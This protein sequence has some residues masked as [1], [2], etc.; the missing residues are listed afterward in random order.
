MKSG[1]PLANSESTNLKN[2]NKNT[3]KIVVQNDTLLDSENVNKSMQKALTDSQAEAKVKL[4]PDNPMVSGHINMLHLESDT[5]MVEG[6]GTGQNK[7]IIQGPDL[8]SDTSSDSSDSDD[9]TD[10]VI[11]LSP[12]NS[13]F[14]KLTNGQQ[15]LVLVDSGSTHS[16]IS[17]SVVAQHAD[18]R[19]IRP[20]KLAEP[21]RLNIAN[22]SQ[23][24]ACTKLNFA[25]T[26]Q[27][28]ELD[29]EA[30]VIPD[31]MGTLDVIIG[32]Q[33]LKKYSA[34]LNFNSHK[35]KLRSRRLLNCLK[36]QAAMQ[37]APMST[38]EV[39]IYGKIPKA[40]KSRDIVLKATGIGKLYL[41]TRTMVKFKGN[42]CRILLLNT[43]DKVVRL[44]KGTKV[45]NIDLQYS[46]CM[47][48]QLESIHINETS[49]VMF[50][51]DES[52]EGPQDIDHLPPEYFTHPDMIKDGV[53]LPPS[54]NDM[55]Y[56]SGTDMEDEVTKVFAQEPTES[57]GSN[58]IDRQQVKE[59]NLYQYPFLTEDDPRISQL[60]HEILNEQIDLQTDCLLG[61]TQKQQFRKLLEKHR[62]SFSLYGE[63]GNSEHSV[64]LEVTD[65]SPKWIRP[66][67]ASPEEKTIIDREMD[68]LHKLGVIEPG[69]SSFTSPVMLIPKKD[70]TKRCVLDL[71]LLN[72]RLQRLQYSF[73][74]VDDCLEIIGIKQSSVLSVLDLR[75]AFFAIKLDPESY[76]Y[77]GLSTYAGGRSFYFCRL[78]MGLS[79]S[80]SVFSHY[81]NQVLSKIPGHNEFVTSYMDDL[82]IHSSSIQ[83]HFH[84]VQVILEALTQ[85][86]LKISPKKSL[87]FRKKVQYLG[88]TI[89]IINGKPYLAVQNSKIST[90][91]RLKPPTSVSKIRG[92]AG[93]VNYLARF[94]PK[95][96]DLLRPLRRLT[97]KGAKFIWTP[98]CQKN[99]QEI[100]DLL[101]TP[102]VLM[103]P[104][105][106]GLITVCVDTSRIAVG[107]AI[108]QRESKDSQVDRLIGYY[109]KA[110][111]PVCQSYSISELECFGIFCVISAIRLLK[112]R[113]FKVVT[114]HSALVDMTVSER[115]LPTTRLK[116]FFEKLSAYQFDLYYR[117]GSQMYISD[118]LSRSDYQAE[119][120][121]LVQPMALVT[122]RQQAK[123][124][125]QVNKQ[126]GTGIAENQLTGNLYHKDKHL[127]DQQPV[128]KPTKVINNVVEVQ[129]G[130]SGTLEGSQNVNTF[131]QPSQ[132]P[133]THTTPPPLEIEQDIVQQGDVGEKL[134]P[135]L[136]NNTLVGHSLKYPPQKLPIPQSTLIPI[137]PADR[138]EHRE[139][140][141]LYISPDR[142]HFQ[143]P[144]DLFDNVEMTDIR[145]GRAIPR[146]QDLDQ[147]IGEVRKRSL[148]DFTEPLRQQDISVQQQR[149]AFFKPIYQF[150]ST[151]VL[152]PNS[153]QAKIIKQNADDYVL[154]KQILFKIIPNKAKTDF[155]MTLC[156]P[157]ASVP[158]I[159]ANYHDTLFA[160]HQGVTKS[161]YTLKQR[162]YIPKLFDKLVQ[163][164]Q[165]CSVCQTRK[166]LTSASEALDYIPRISSSFEIFA[167][168]YMDIK[169]LFD[170]YEGFCYLLV[171]VDQAT[172]FVMAFPLKRKSAIAVA[173]ILL[174]KVCL[175]WG[176]F[177]KII[178]DHG[179]EFVNEIVKY[180]TTALGIEMKVCAEMFHQ[181]NL[182]ERSIRTV[183]ELLLNRLS[184]HAR[185]WPMFVQAV[186]YS[187]NTAQ[188]RTLQG[189][190][191]YQLVFGREP[192]DFLG[193]DFQKNID[194]LPISYTEYAETIRSRLQ[195]YGDTANQL[196]A[197][198]QEKQHLK[199]AQTHKTGLTYQKGDIVFLL[200]PRGSDIT[201]PS[202]KFKV[203]Y[204]GPLI[205]DELID[206]RYATLTD[207]SGKKLYGIF[208]VKRLKKGHFRC[209]DKNATTLTE[210]KQSISKMDGQNQ[211]DLALVQNRVMVCTSNLHNHQCAD[212][213]TYFQWPE[214]PS[215]EEE[216]K[217]TAVIQVEPYAYSIDTGN[218]REQAIRC[219]HKSTPKVGEHMDM[220]RTRLKLGRIEILLGCGQN[221]AFWFT[222]SELQQGLQI[223]I[224]CQQI[225]NKNGKPTGRVYLYT[226]VGLNGGPSVSKSVICVGSPAKYAK[227]WFGKHC[228][229]FGF[230][231]VR[232]N[233]TV[234]IIPDSAFQHV[235]EPDKES[236]Q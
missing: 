131:T 166:K 135:Y 32:S 228:N 33:D 148:R 57:K 128:A 5:H 94:L 65:T 194:A 3:R 52:T 46:Y 154:V 21:L 86:R 49:T 185:N 50:I 104:N 111:P 20:E 88:H 195:E 236:E 209:A 174:Q 211:K 110:C 229:V 164:I 68:R 152:P 35:L 215:N 22:G 19:K 210:V 43:T 159:L 89:E 79:I 138:P 10:E 178:T 82:M 156:V 113:Y 53:Q 106:E 98:E 77:A 101:V 216:K 41:P 126:P 122:T 218:R 163:Y 233:P 9:Y 161:Y 81:I 100:K 61:K 70:K 123:R 12:T 227:M 143:E 165:S 13:I 153:R 129:A 16:I 181:S 116:K 56:L 120:L 121:P 87:F 71:R 93:A 114:D 202:L 186:L 72:R 29:I 108:W 17:Q 205:V 173:E 91:Q 69:L 75:D 208:S 182:S 160:N 64:K 40:L 60:P 213:A 36:L 147:F 184:G 139:E 7:P 97:R 102:P 45:A 80:P 134:N 176:P 155:R 74:L 191:P 37:I 103:L 234:T 206:R 47:Y 230:K 15:L 127:L 109:S 133:L 190:S 59:H 170:S 175:I 118:F 200:F 67:Y 141:D 90:I 188:H 146:Q 137:I 99:W 38:R 196:Q 235:S 198:S 150:L 199:Y 26:I 169:Y 23:I 172:R 145:Y 224:K 180:L 232:F 140:A 28:A 34:S 226:P 30:Y 44:R 25:I 231:A 197:Q 84:H 221:L 124:L 8:L 125:L 63:I 78:A 179:T 177:S 193:L 171:L 39:I 66:Y 223:D 85:A 83:E 11:K 54:P 76:K 189:F 105:R 62:D 220:V 201:A 27:Q 2:I 204:I 207:M 132:L 167:V 6:S 187:I 219:T 58:I 117:K 217:P 183:S 18:L 225:V 162:Y 136:I 96:A 1:R 4:N 130:K 151:G 222:I 14:G 203:S 24:V 92:F 107:A 214:G 73:P 42:Q 51:H 212:L 112:S 119:D 48:E 142:Q 168:V 149:D 192:R 55:G 95:L 115:Q 144:V 158:Y 157:E 31:Q